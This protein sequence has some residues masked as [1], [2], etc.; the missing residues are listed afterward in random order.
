MMMARKR[1][2]W[3]S[4]GYSSPKKEA[5]DCDG[6]KSREETPEWARKDIVF[7]DS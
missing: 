5:V 6:P 7:T 1:W 4:Y 3:R 2:L